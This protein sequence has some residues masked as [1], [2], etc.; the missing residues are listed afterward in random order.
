MRAQFGGYYTSNLAQKVWLFESERKEVG[1]RKEKKRKER[2]N[3]NNNDNKKILQL[4]DDVISNCSRETNEVRP[5][6]E[7]SSALDKFR[8]VFFTRLIACRVIGC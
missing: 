8:S 7:K 2:N 6:E 1:E 5:E 4:M 3:N